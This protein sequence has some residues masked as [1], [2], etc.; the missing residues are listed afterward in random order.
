MYRI[1]AYLTLALAGSALGAVEIS[2]REPLVLDAS[3]GWDFRERPNFCRASRTFG[4][5]E[6]AGTLWI[7]RGGTEPTFN[8]TFMG[9]PFRHPKG[10]GI[11]VRFGGEPEFIRSYLALETSRGDPV[12]RMYGVL[13]SLP[14]F[15]RDLDSVVTVE[16]PDADTIKAIDSLH[17]R[18]SIVK[19]VVLETGS[20]GPAFEFLERCTSKLAV[21]HTSAGRAILGEASA[22]VPIEP[23]DWIKRHHYPNYLAT[24]RMQGWVSV[25]MSVNAEGRPSSCFVTQASKPQL[26]D[27]AVC[28]TLMH[29]ARFE[30]ARDAYGEPIDSFVEYKQS[31]SFR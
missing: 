1:I 22:P 12:V 11:Y 28:G 19:P 31:F 30:P 2:A 3:S 9:R 24:A 26:F 16:Q 5:G 17:L 21:R 29:R 6:D 27:D 7:E 14:E 23:E 25:R 15:D 8:L 18:G 20:L 13:L 10:G 4:S